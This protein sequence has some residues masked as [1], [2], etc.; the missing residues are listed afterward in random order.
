MKIGD[1]VIVRCGSTK[2]FRRGVVRPAGE[3]P[4]LGE[5]VKSFLVDDDLI[6]VLGEEVS[7]KE[8]LPRFSFS[9]ERFA[10][11]RD[12]VLNLDDRKIYLPKLHTG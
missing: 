8:E 5:G 7:E 2:I 1:E 10:V 6:V 4:S 9:L 11:A 12:L 3:R